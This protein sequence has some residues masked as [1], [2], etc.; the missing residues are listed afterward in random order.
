MA[1]TDTAVRNAKPK[2]KPYKLADE[3]SMFLLVSPAGAK[4]WRYKYRFGGKEKMLSLGVYPDVGLAAARDK[5]EEARKLLAAGVDPSQNRRAQRAA[6]VERATNSFETVAREWHT[7]RLDQWTEGH[8]DR[9]LARLE[10]DVFPWIGG[11][12]V[13]EVSP[14]EL[15][16]VLRRIESRGANETA[17]RVHQICGQVFR[18]AVATARAGRDPSA[19]LRGAL[20][21]VTGSH[22]AAIT[23]P[24]GI[25]A[26]LRDLDG[27][28]GSF[29]TKCALRLAPLLF[30][31][32]GEL[33]K[34]EWSEFDI[35]KKE[36]RIPAEKMKSRETHIVPLS[37]Q[38]LAILAELR[39]LTGQGPHLFPSVRTSARPMSDNTVN[40]ALR[41]MGYTRDEMTGHGFR[42]IASTL[43]NE[44]GWHRD[45][46]ERQLAH[47][48]R[49]QVRAAYNYAE[50]LP[51]RRK[52]MQWW[53]DHLAGLAA[54][55]NVI[56]LPRKAAKAT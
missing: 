42:T 39:P 28:S 18:Y 38:A 29:V 31:R 22:H 25:G 8:A 12:P 55:G 9:I 49:D 1:L 43:L 53:A 51:E 34:A 52:M 21:P 41:R 30:V 36:W 10:N 13:A 24:A 46:I 26:L 27:Y 2:A 35:E 56:P 23:D 40:A 5:R 20:Q 11:R 44:H 48:E 50:H 3:R 14:P 45:A 7:A 47:G 54:G 37:S 6:Q 4:W 15:L 33:R 32:P 16:A 19:D 17:H